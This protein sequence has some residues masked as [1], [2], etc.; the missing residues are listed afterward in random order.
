MN[1]RDVETV[2][3]LSSEAVDHLHNDDEQE[4]ETALQEALEILERVLGEAG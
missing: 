4:A 3:H 2:A 1:V